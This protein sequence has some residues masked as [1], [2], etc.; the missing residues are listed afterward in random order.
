MSKPLQSIVH[1]EVRDDRVPASDDQDDLQVG[2]AFDDET[3]TADAPE[4]ADA[5]TET[6]TDVEVET[7]SDDVLSD[8]TPAQAQRPVTREE[9]EDP[10]ALYARD[11][12]RAP[13]MT[14]P[15]ERESAAAI[16][17]LD[18][19]V[20]ERLLEDAS[21]AR[22]V[23]VAI[24]PSFE[25]V[26]RELV[27]LRRAVAV[28]AKA[29][30]TKAARTALVRAAERS[31]PR[32]R[33]LDP[34][35]QLVTLA[36]S[37]AERLAAGGS[38]AARATA[39]ANIRKARRAADVA[40][41]EFV[42]RNLRLVMSIARR[43]RV[44]GMPL[45]DLVQEG[46]LGLLKAMDRFDPARGFRFS[47]YA[48]WWIRHHINRAMADK[49]RLVRV[50][51]HRLDRHN[52]IER[53]RRRLVGELGRDPTSTE[54]AKA[55]GLSSEQLQEIAEQR[56]ERVVSL[57]APRSGDEDDDR[58]AHDWFRDPHADEASPIER[59]S[60]DVDLRLLKRA[61]GGLK[62]IEVAVL[63]KRFGMGE[64]EERTLADIGEEH[65][66][67]RERIRQIEQQALAR[68]RKAMAET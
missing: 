13:A 28:A 50:P 58:A 34:D 9:L 65:G 48:V 25:K 56:F 16:V 66:L 57:D 11:L 10:M 29:R 26:P 40:R 51:V 63:T 68:L 60:R 5:E 27:A 33:I 38:D 59:L 22:A 41:A 21:I 18:H 46:N 45:L 61:L 64:R 8:K 62:P 7:D 32:L 20:W 36:A 37:A 24:T 14:P 12:A 42:R 35:R 31:A 17:T 1:D 49:S 67:S 30:A 19:M 39:I 44:R 53:A 55:T 54:L 43:Y 3:T 52:Q 23:L 4:R 2:G 47:T 15:E 6:P